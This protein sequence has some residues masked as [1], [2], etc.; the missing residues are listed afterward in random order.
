VR[1]VPIIGWLPMMI[2]WFGIGEPSKVIFIAAGAFFPAAFNTHRGVKG[3]AR[4]YIEVAQAFECGKLRMLA[5]VI[6]P[7]A[8]PSILTGLR[9]SLSTSWM[10]VVAAEL[11]MLTA[12]GIGNMMAQGRELFQMDIVLVG[13]AV[14][15][16]VGF[17]MNH[18]IKL[19]EARLAPR[20]A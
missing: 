20:G 8:L 16:A 5:T 13:M 19:L 11:V 18:A 12:G 14:I 1:Q 15:G 4:E 10:L 2:V 3:V 7:A 6:L 9:F 17:V